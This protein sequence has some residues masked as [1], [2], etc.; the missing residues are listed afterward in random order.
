M[1]V[2][3]SPR[4][5]SPHVGWSLRAAAVVVSLGLGLGACSSGKSVDK[6]KR[7]DRG[8]SGQGASSDTGP[9]GGYTDTTKTTP[10]T[11]TQHLNLKLASSK[12][13][14]RSVDIPKQPVGKVPSAVA[15]VDLEVSAILRS[16]DGK[17]VTAVWAAHNTGSQSAN[18]GGTRYI[19]EDQS[20]AETSAA[21]LVD[22]ANLK[23]YLV[24]R[25]D[26]DS[27]P[28]LCSDGAELVNLDPGK[29]AYLA[30]VFPA[31][32][33]GTK[34]LTFQIPSGVVPNVPVTDA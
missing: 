7:T 31:P 32:P 14:A 29:R 26:G 9:S 5:P 24:F 34:T 10:S 30:G 1:T 20:S 16:A 27:G 2:H 6:A 19:S 4:P 33:A 13:G 25:Q 23:Q 15:G 8:T 21:T 3:P 11:K 17:S 28:C 12:Y 18:P 22:G